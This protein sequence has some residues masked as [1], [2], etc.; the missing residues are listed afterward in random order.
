MENALKHHGEDPPMASPAEILELIETWRLLDLPRMDDAGIEEA[1]RE[2]LYGLRSVSRS[3]RR[4]R[5]IKRIYR[6]RLKRRRGAQNDANWPWIDSQ[7]LVHPVGGWVPLGRCNLSGESALYCAYDFVTALREIGVE[8]GDEVVLIGYDLV[9]ADLARVVGP[10]NP[11]RYGSD[12]PIFEGDELVSY[13][14]VRDFI[15]SE[16]SKPVGTETR[17]L[18]RVS[19][20]ICRE[21]FD[22]SLDG[23]VYPS[24]ESP[25]REC[26]AL[27]D[28]SVSR[29]VSIRGATLARVF[30]VQGR[31]FAVEKLKKAIIHE[32]QT[33]HWT[34]CA[35]QSQWVCGCEQPTHAVP[36]PV[37]HS[38]LFD[39]LKSRFRRVQ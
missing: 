26:L 39:W 13:H 36:L 23:W 1:L 25:A 6:A 14:I 16:F 20:A 34:P 15:R 8:E 11:R 35:A 33:V 7:H 28:T 18:Y 17:H 2:L 5:G 30:A 9:D 3:T 27:R 29:R 22:E 38:P 12:E 31:C 4:I 32:D 21:W 19:A 10:F 24:V 37:R